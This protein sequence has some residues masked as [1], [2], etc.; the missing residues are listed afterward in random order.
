MQPSPH[1]GAHNYLFAIVCISLMCVCLIPLCGSVKRQQSGGKAQ[2]GLSLKRCWRWLLRRERPG[3]AAG[4]LRCHSPLM[5][6]TET[7]ST[8]IIPKYAAQ[9]VD[10]PPYARKIW[11]VTYFRSQHPHG[12]SDHPW[13]LKEESNYIRGQTIPDLDP[14][15]TRP[16]RTP[17]CSSFGLVGSFLLA[18]CANIC[19]APKHKHLYQLTVTFSTGETDVQAQKI[20]FAHI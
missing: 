15:V 3:G 13:L 8:R 2:V 14:D 10:L 17:A 7:R 18:G 1:I 11:A 6:P 12:L 19:A 5:L 20:Q 4:Q 16:K 9:N